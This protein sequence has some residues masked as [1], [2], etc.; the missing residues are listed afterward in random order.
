MWLVVSIRSS[1]KRENGFGATLPP[2]TASHTCICNLLEG[3]DKIRSGQ[4]TVDHHTDIASYAL[5]A[6]SSIRHFTPRTPPAS[7]S[8][9]Q[10]LSFQRAGI[11]RMSPFS[12]NVGNFGFDR[13]TASTSNCIGFFGFSQPNV[14]IPPFVFILLV[15][16]FFAFEH[17]ASAIGV[18]FI[19]N[20]IMA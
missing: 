10:H 6:A 18:H 3:F 14:L 15:F 1:G 4:S 7:M 11:Q 12:S 9:S 16:S 17:S 8:A 13:T 5:S 2:T 20:E 19:T